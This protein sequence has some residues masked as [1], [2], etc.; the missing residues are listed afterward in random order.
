MLKFP[1][2]IAVSAAVALGACTDPGALGTV[3]PSG[4][5]I[6]QKRNTGAAIGAAS[7]AVLGAVL[8]D[9]KTAVAGAG[10]WRSDW[11]RHRL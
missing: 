9:R 10:G 2:V 6:N 7:G 3:G 11:W 1:T 8:G 5:P 4:E